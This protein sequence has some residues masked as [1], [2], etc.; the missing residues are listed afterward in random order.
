MFTFNCNQIRFY[1]IEAP[2]KHVEA[3]IFVCSKRFTQKWMLFRSG[4]WCW[5]VRIFANACLFCGA[6]NEW[7][8]T[9][10]PTPNDYHSIVYSF[11]YLPFSE[12]NSAFPKYISYLFGSVCLAWEWFDYTISVFVW[13]RS[14]FMLSNSIQLFSSVSLLPFSFLFSFG[15]LCCVRRNSI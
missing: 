10:T 8:N 13:D 6:T 1:A 9:P 5:V 14:T 3:C 12:S 15:A 4:N 7:C 11:F 2:L